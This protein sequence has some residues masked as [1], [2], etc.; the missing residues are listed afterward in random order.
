MI[1]REAMMIFMIVFPKVMLL[2]KIEVAIAWHKN[3]V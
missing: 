3:N 2:K 1:F